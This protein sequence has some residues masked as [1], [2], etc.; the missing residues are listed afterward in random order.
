VAD[1]R[2]AQAEQ[3]KGL[4]NPISAL[5]NAATIKDYREKHY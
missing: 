5:K 4:G 2:K 3:K 1:Q